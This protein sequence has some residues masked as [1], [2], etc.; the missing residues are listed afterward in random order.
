MSEQVTFRDFAGALMGGDTANAASV[1]E[2]LLGV[3]RA[4]AERAT[5]Y[6]G[7][8]MTAS[9]AFVQKAMGMRQVVENRD[10]AAL[11]T[12]LVECFGLATETAASAAATVMAR[13]R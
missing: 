5:A 9:P 8:Q 13:Y 4:T 2:T 10:E 6:F 12:L 1:L 3:D 7:E 11:A